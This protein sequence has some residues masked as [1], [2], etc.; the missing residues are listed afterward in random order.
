MLMVMVTV[1][2]MATVTGMVTVAVTMTGTARDADARSGYMGHNMDMK[3]MDMDMNGTFLSL[4]PLPS[5]CGAVRC[6]A[7]PCL[8]DRY[9]TL[10]IGR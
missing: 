5:R 10:G 4:E 1:M 3:K 7:L 2:V 6:V 9:C 8:L